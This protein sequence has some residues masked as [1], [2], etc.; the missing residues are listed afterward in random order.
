MF[1]KEWAIEKNR[2][3]MMIICNKIWFSEESGQKLAGQAMVIRKRG[4]LSD[5]VVK[6]IKRETDFE[7]KQNSTEK[8][9]I[10]GSTK[11]T[12]RQVYED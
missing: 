9:R 3:R 1:P 2:K 4:W 8:E 11:Q 6:L 5:M 10:P 7:V 12:I